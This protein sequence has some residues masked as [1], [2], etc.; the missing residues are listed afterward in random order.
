MELI[1][2]VIVVC[3]VCPA[4]NSWGGDVYCCRVGLAGCDMVP[5]SSPLK[6]VD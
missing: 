2:S 3:D 1:F 5:S 6:N 4:P